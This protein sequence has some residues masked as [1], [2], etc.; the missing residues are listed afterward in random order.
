MAAPSVTRPAT[1]IYSGGT[2]SVANTLG[3]TA[4]ATYGDSGM[5]LPNPSINNTYGCRINLASPVNVLAR[6][7][8]TFQLVTQV[9]AGLGYDSLRIY[10]F[11]SAGNRS[12][13]LLYKYGPAYRT[14]WVDSPSGTQGSEGYFIANG[15]ENTDAVIDFTIALNAT[16]EDSSGTLNWADI[17]AFELYADRSNI[18]ATNVRVYVVYMAAIDEPYLTGGDVANPI[19]LSGQRS[20]FSNWSS[21]VA[22]YKHFRSLRPAPALINNS[23]EG[24]II[25]LTHG[26]TI[27][28]GSTATRSESTGLSIVFR[29]SYNLTVLD[30][31]PAI[32]LAN[33][34][35]R[36]LKWNLGSS[37]YAYHS[38]FLFSGSLVDTGDYDISI[39][40]SN[41]ADT[42]FKNGTIYNAG[43]VTI[44]VAVHDGLTC[45][46]C[47][48]ILYDGVATI[49]NASIIN[50]TYSGTRGLV[51]NGAPG[52]YSG[53]FYFADNTGGHDIE[54]EPTSTG[55]FVL[56]NISVK[57]GQTLKIHNTHASTAITVQIPAGITYSTSTAGG[58]ITVTNPP[59]TQS[60][61]IDGAVAGTRIQIYDTDTNTELYNG[62][63]GSYPYTW[64]DPSPYVADRPIRLRAM[65][66]AAA[67]AKLFIDTPIGTATA[68][69]PD[70]SY[71]INQQD[72]DVYAANAINGSTV[73]GITID[74]ANL[75]INVTA[76]TLSWATIYAYETYWLSTSAGI[77]DE[78]RIITAL[79]QANYLF[80]N[81][82]IKNV[83]TGTLTLTGGYGRDATTG[84][85]VDIIDTSGNNIFPLPDHVVNNIVTVG[86]AN[87]ITGDASTI[88]TELSGKPTLA[89]IEGSTILS[90][91]T[92]VAARPTLAQIEASA[93]LAKESTINT[94]IDS[95]PT[96]SEITAAVPDVGDIVTGVFNQAITT[97]IHANMK[98]QNDYTII[99]GSSETDKFRSE[100]VP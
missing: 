99:G 76:S 44:D 74:D 90:K 3:L 26:L 2:T 33:T 83:G 35:R 16:P 73:T 24:S 72:D 23:T 28:N 5:T 98:K 89:Q 8:I 6:K 77:T 18:A 55:T 40:G 32:Q 47:V 63:P 10:F 49:T 17:V 52:T 51:I 62:V 12:G 100:T 61:T 20:L 81:F 87:I 48:E 84:S 14:F 80:E 70:L 45:K 41:T 11:D 78:G 57:S 34:T 95:L 54:I 64:T 82:S 39:T 31:Y 92:T 36:L 93:V 22:P 50:N 88:L 30:Q 59:V 38:E 96:L 86:G 65:Y 97:P 94:G 68:L 27:G 56:S 7:Y 85:I 75:L 25:T 46:K 1:N 42:L 21:L 13:F 58:A 91:E 66:T 60:V 19:T 43:T 53:E 71:L 15:S 37:D 9:I 4:P 69:N 67:S 79:D 29:P